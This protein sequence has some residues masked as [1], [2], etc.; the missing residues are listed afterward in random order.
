MHLSIGILGNAA[1]TRFA[2][3]PSSVGF[4]YSGRMYFFINSSPTLYSNTSVISWPTGVSPVTSWVGS[5]II[6]SLRIWDGNGLRPLWLTRMF[7]FVVVT[8]LIATV[9]VT[10]T[11]A[12]LSVGNKSTYN[13][14]TVGVNF[15]CFPPKIYF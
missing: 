1:I 15:S 8:S 4:I 5:S 7:V 10:I 6:S 11:S 3:V 13:A 12:S 14:F 9:V 2:C